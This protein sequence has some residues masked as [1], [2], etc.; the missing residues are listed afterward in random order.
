MD[1]LE[2]FLY[3]ISYKFPKGYPD[4]KD[5]NDLAI[6]E[7]E[8]A[9]LDINLNEPN[10]PYYQDIQQNEIIIDGEDIDKVTE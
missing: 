8:L 3:N 4:L 7:N 9:K 2:Q 5:K 1:I 6:L 10:P